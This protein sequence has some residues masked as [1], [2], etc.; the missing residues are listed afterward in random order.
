M[1][2]TLKRRI[3]LAVGGQF[4]H[5]LYQV[6]IAL[7]APPGLW[8]V[9]AAVGVL[10]A[11]VALGYAYLH[12]SELVEELADDRDR[13]QAALSDVR[14]E[15]DDLDAELTE[16]RADLE[17]AREELAAR[18]D[19]PA[20]V[21]GPTGPARS[22]GGVATAGNVSIGE[23]DDLVD[24][25]CTT[26]DAAGEGD[27]TRR[28]D[29]DNPSEAL[30]RL[31]SEFNEMAE[32]FQQTIDTAAEFSG[33]VAGSSEQVTT[34]TQAVTESSENVAETVDDIATVFQDQHEQINQ[35]SEE[36]GEM[37]A[38]VEEVAASSN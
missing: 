25:F 33:E 27:L 12:L 32:A 5:A 29:T 26:I 8:P 21:P 15:R 23:Y 3:G 9:L 13:L 19:E 4:V 36:M 31:A 28:L 18:P 30:N 34:A 7:V 24:E 11:A 1:R 17:A 35:I 20:T 2:A 22:D 10:P 16:V 6:G 14:A 37:S 38:T